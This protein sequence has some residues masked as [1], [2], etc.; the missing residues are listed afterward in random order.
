MSDV[1]SSPLSVAI[2]AAV[3]GALAAISISNALSNLGAAAQQGG[4]SRGGRRRS[5]RQDDEH[6]RLDYDSE[7]GGGSYSAFN[8][9]YNSP[10]QSDGEGAFVSPDRRA[11]RRRHNRRHRQ[12]QQLQTTS[13]SGSMTPR[14]RTHTNQQPHE[15]T[16]SVADAM[17]EGGLDG[18]WQG[19]SM[20]DARLHSDAAAAAAAA[21]PAKEVLWDLQKG[22][23]R[24][25]MGVS[26]RPEIS[27]FERRAL[28]IQQFPSVAVLGCS[29]SRVPIEIVFDQGLGDI[30]VVRV[31]GNCLDTTTTGSL[32][33]AVNH[34]K[35]KVVVIMGHEGCGA[36][37]A[38]QLSEDQ[39]R[40]EPTNLSA[41]LSQMK[42][43]LDDHRLQAIH[44]A[45][46]R[47]RESVVTNV[48]KQLEML[49]SND[50]IMEKV[51]SGQML[52][53]GAFYEISSGIVDFFD[54]ISAEQIEQM[55]VDAANGEAVLAATQGQ[56]KYVG[57][58]AGRSSSVPSPARPNRSTTAP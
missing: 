14:L 5:E 46:A 25:W 2:A 15:L 48:R 3:G 6:R 20:E 31:A 7:G 27:A 9:A 41:M 8:S 40:Q 30:F 33:Y 26:S 29:D 16:Q 35:V 13:T 19:F 4:F 18:E 51:R 58:R 45:R 36:V 1:F 32:E 56:T 21:K 11:T 38:A 39:I 44:D 10:A 17:I 24:F 12:R 43:G 50:T 28:I 47:D 55:A 57:A 49:S 22:N 42:K 54:E 52:V 34:L 23:T 37:K 53:V